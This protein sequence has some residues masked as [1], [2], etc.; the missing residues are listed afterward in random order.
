MK[1]LN[2]PTLL[3]Y[4][5]KKHTL[6]NFLNNNLLNYLEIHTFNKN[7]FLCTLNEKLLYMYFLVDGKYKVTT[8]LSSGKSLLLCFNTP[9][10]IMGDIELIENPYAD[11]N[12][13]A[14]ENCICLALPIS[15]IKDY[16]YDDPVFL[17][18]II[19][20]LQKKLRRNSSYMS[21]NILSPIENRFASYLISSLP[22][23]SS[24]DLIV[25]IDGINNLSDLL[26]ASY[27]HLNRVIKNLSDEKIIKK[28]KNS[29][30]ILNLNK[31][32]DLATDEYKH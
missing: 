31:L 5:I 24:T 11:C 30:Q 7:E 12:V 21:I 28:Y 14:L 25:D 10:S 26:G 6:N 8:L 23:N 16:G 18:F 22:S 19:S 1:K 13:Q 3:E 32:K 29:I 27:R 15:K 9:L 17:R 20:S 2:N 4:Y